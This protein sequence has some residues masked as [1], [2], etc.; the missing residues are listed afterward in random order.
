MRYWDSSAL[1][2]LVLGEAN[3]PKMRELLLADPHIATWAWTWVEIA[4][5]VERRSREGLFTPLQ[6]RE[7]LERVQR[8]AE[9]CDEVTDVIAVRRRALGVLA[10]HPVRAA[11]AAQLGAALVI[12]HDLP[13]ELF[14]VCLDARLT[15]AAEREGLRVPGV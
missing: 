8:L 6:R 14:F 7:A 13:T 10:R 11:D 5:A 9:V 15:D 12:A 3:S 1:V 2:P 4:G